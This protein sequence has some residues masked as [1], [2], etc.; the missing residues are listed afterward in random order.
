[1]VVCPITTRETQSG[2]APKEHNI[3]YGEDLPA[4]PTRHVREIVMRPMTARVVRTLFHVA[5]Q[6]V[7]VSVSSYDTKTARHELPARTS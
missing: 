7:G 6:S 2:D 1:M 3:R 5:E 4:A